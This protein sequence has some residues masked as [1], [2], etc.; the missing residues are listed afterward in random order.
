M[1]T[2]SIVTQSR[3]VLFPSLEALTLD[4]TPPLALPG[5]VMRAMT[6][7]IVASIVTHV[8]DRHTSQMSTD[9]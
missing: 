7:A 8:R 9:S 5:V 1:G 3:Q 6:R 2:V 4:P